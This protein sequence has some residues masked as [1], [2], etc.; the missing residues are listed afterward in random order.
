[1]LRRLPQGS[2][3]LKLK[4]P[5]SLSIRKAYSM[6]VVGNT[7]R[8]FL[9]EERSSSYDPESYYPARIGE[10]I[11]EEYRLISKLGWGTASTVWLAR[12][13]SR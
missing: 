2:Q 13:I 6:A 7:A 5:Y 12:T 11:H 1:M 8:P 9:E 10:I 3:Y 4:H